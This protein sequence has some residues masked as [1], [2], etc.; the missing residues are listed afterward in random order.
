MDYLESRARNKAVEQA[1]AEGRV[2]DSL[3]V[4]MA[5]IKRHEAGEITFD[6]MQAELKRIKRNAKKNGQV[7]RSQAW[8]G[9]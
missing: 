6:E 5:L 1:E 8:R 4:R 2:A 7:T 3:E 9:Y